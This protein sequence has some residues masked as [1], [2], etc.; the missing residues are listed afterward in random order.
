MSKSKLITTAIRD[1][2][3]KLVIRHQRYGNELANEGERIRRRTGAKPAKVIHT[4]A[5][6]SCA[7]GFNPYKV[8]D[9]A[10]SISYA[11][12]KAL[13]MGTYRPRSAVVH[14]IPKPGG[15]TREVAVFQIA[16]SAVSRLVFKRLLAKNANRFSSRCYAYR[17]DISLHDAVADIAS[18]LAGKRR[19]FVAEFDF[20]KYFDSISHEHL[21]KLLQ[22]RRF[23][24]TERERQVLRGFMEAAKVPLAVYDPNAPPNNERGIPQGTS[25]SLFLANLA[26]LPLDQGL[27]RLGV[28]FARYA[29]DTFIWSSS[30]S[31]ICDAFDELDRAAELMG[32]ALNFKKSEGISLLAPEEPPSELRRKA[33]VDF[34]GYRIDADGISIK[35]GMVRRVKRHISQIIFRNLLE[36]P[37][38][39]NLLPARY[40]PAVDRDYVVMVLQ[41]RRYL[42]GDLSETRLRRFLTGD[43]PRM[44]YKGLMSFYPIVDDEDLLRHLDG[45]MLHTVHSTL[46]RRASLI[47]MAGSLPPPHDLTRDELVKFSGL[48][49]AGYQIDLRLPS[50]VRISRLLRRA[51]TLH[52]ANAI[53]NSKSGKYYLI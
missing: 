17:T 37:L 13:K 45:W 52:G 43:V 27:E 48:T 33:A 10:E 26:G 7:L 25:V 32:V 23:H 30:Y 41:L 44:H 11:V 49:S 9:R 34:I 22:D 1:E 5:Y 8:R 19:M 38:Q 6:W 40:A 53:A 29:D 4:P 46:L 14:E 39:G 12:T 20:S 47:P 42:Y 16:D 51:S 24:V 2:A 35:P 50:F 36:A 21:H 15:G 28:G 18:D 3:T 31:K